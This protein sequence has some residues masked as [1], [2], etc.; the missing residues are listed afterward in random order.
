MPCRGERN[1]C[2]M[3]ATKV[4]LVCEIVSMLSKEVC[5]IESKIESRN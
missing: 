1:S 5:A 3:E 2:E 4:D